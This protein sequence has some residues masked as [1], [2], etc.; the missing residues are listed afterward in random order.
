[1]KKKKTLLSVVPALILSISIVGSVS[2]GSPGLPHHEYEGGGSTNE[3]I[4]SGKC[5]R[6]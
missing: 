2:A 6:P 1:M 5:I 3:C 4:K